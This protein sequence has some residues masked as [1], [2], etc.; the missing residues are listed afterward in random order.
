MK[1]SLIALLLA[2]AML[3][4]VVPAMAATSSLLPYEGEKITY[5]AF[6]ADLVTE[7]AET[8]VAQAY[9]K[10]LGNIELNWELVPISDIATKNNVYLNSGDIPDIMWTSGNTSVIQNYGDMGYWLDL[11]KYLE[12]MPNFS[13]WLENYPHNKELYAHDGGLY[14]IVCMDYYDYISETWFYNKT[15]L[16]ALGY[17]EP[18][19]TWDEMYEMMVAYRDANPDGLAYINNGNTSTYLGYWRQLGGWEVSEW[20]FNEETQKWDNAVINEESGYKALITHMNL[21]YTEGFIH[22]EFDAVAGDQIKQYNL[23]G[24]WL[25]GTYYNGT[26]EAEIHKTADLPFELGTFTTPALKEGDDRYGIITVRNNALPG[27]AYFAS[28]EA[29]QPEILASVLDYTLSE[30]ANDLYWWGIKDVSYTVDANGTKHYIDDY[31]TNTDKRGEVG[32]Q[33]VHLQRLNFVQDWFSQFE[34]AMP[35]AQ[36]AQDKLADELRTGELKHMLS[37]RGTPAFT[38]E[39]NETRSFSTTPMAT[40]K[41]EQ[42]LLFITGERSMDEWD[43]F[44]EEYKAMGDWEEVLEVYNNAQQVV[45]DM[46]RSYPDFIPN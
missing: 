28:G 8:P 14:A 23:T 17:T 45:Y 16:D 40:Y 32:I 36:I 43:A 7:K 44:V 10:G 4:S 41:N 26:P 12:Y 33:G 2:V 34:A 6:G 42:I 20:Y 3:L 38:A 15:A 19:K 24:N 35:V 5:H 37:S 39:E 25:F 22:P 13:W 29:E 1:K 11:D 46:T 30:E 27:W 9:Y 18:P 31:G 21:L